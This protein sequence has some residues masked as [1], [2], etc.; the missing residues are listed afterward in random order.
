VFLAI[1]GNK[2]N[3]VMFAHESSKDGESVR[4]TQDELEYGG[5]V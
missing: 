3:E 4:V 2:G 1:F 5:E